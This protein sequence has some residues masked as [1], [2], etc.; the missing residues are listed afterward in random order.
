MCIFNQNIEENLKQDHDK[1]SW[2]NIYNLTLATNFF[3]FFFFYNEL[4]T[5]QLWYQKKRRKCT[6]KHAYFAKSTKRN[7][8]RTPNT[9]K[10]ERE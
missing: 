3:F 7:I 2:K 9:I 1:Q 10:K 6:L 4:Q 8:N 5:L